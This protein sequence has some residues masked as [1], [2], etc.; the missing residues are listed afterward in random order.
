MEIDAVSNK[1]KLKQSVYDD[2]KKKGLCLRCG[3]P[4]HQ[5]KACPSR[6][7][8]ISATSSDPADDTVSVVSEN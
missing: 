8:S 4:G 6:S 5:S 7:N 2:R 3:Q 1:W